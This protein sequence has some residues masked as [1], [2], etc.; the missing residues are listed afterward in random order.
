MKQKLLVA[1]LACASCA[2]ADVVY[3]QV[4]DMDTV[5]GHNPFLTYMTYDDFTL[6]AGAT[7]NSITVQAWA[8]DTGYSIGNMDWE[9]CA[10]D[11]AV[12]GAVLYSGNVATVTQVDTGLDVGSYNLIDYTINIADV[13]LSAGSYFLGFRGNG[14]DDIH[15]SINHPASEVN[16]S[17][18]LYYD[19][20]DYVDYLDSGTDA[21]FSLGGTIPEP[22]T[23]AF[24]GIFGVGALAVRRIFMI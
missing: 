9:I 23:F 16:L 20:S 7:V 2:S 10:V 14:A 3:E 11:S 15:L 4:V 22:A 8:Q 6:N 19:G 1:L 24:V 18:L 5:T 17:Q 21:I 12:P 13:S